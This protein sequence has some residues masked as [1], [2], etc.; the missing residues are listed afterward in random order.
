MEFHEKLQQLRKAKGITQEALADALFVSRTA[1][2][3]WESG[4]GYPSIDSLRAIADFFSLTLDELL[5]SR[6][7]LVIAEKEHKQK[8]GFLRDLMLGLL[9]IC[10]SLLLFLPFFARR[11]DGIVYPESLLSLDGVQ[12]YLKASYLAVVVG[13]VVVGIL[14]LALQS[15][16]SR[17]WL[18]IKTKVSLALSEVA[19]ALFIVSS[20]PYAA[21][22]VFVL[23]I[24]KTLVVIKK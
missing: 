1:V 2:S 19:I 5:S 6:E 10:A 3:R 4:R 9:D 16:Q 20:Q 14:L 8:E 22:F 13:V 18:S 11:S 17:L 21:L 24:I 15:C 23:S 7:A 12:T